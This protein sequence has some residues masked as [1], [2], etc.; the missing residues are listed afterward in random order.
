MCVKGNTALVVLTFHVNTEPSVKRCWYVI[1]PII[2]DIKIVCQ[3]KSS[4][5]LKLGYC[6]Q[7]DLILFNIL[8]FVFLKSVEKSVPLEED[9]GKYFEYFFR[10]LTFWAK[11]HQSATTVV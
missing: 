7:V 2:S 11:A 6:I 10:L 5:F 9:K 4:D 1:F 8:I 3:L